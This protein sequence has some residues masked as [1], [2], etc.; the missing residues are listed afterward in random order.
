MGFFGGL[1]TLQAVV[2]LTIVMFIV[3]VIAGII[4]V[5]FFVEKTAPEAF[6]MIKE[7]ME[8]YKSKREKAED[9]GDYDS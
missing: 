3:G 9:D 6:S 5:L 1:I 7:E 8:K 4:L 2:V